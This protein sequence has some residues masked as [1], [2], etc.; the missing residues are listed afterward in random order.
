MAKFAREI[1]SKMN[2]LTQDLT[3]TMGQDT[4]ELQ[5]RVGLHSGSVTG[6]NAYH[7]LSCLETCL[8]ALGNEAHFFMSDSL[9]F[10]AFC[11]VAPKTTSQPV[12][13]VV[14]SLAFNSLEIP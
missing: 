1:I 11:F 2:N 10:L 5:M 14:K 8:L 4:A 12:S 7:I 3:G 9:S 6:T 13:F